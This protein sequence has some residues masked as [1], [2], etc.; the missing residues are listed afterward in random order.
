MEKI[1]CY[2]MYTTVAFGFSS[3]GR[4]PKKY[5]SFLK[6]YFNLRFFFKFHR[7]RHHFRYFLNLILDYLKV[8]FGTL[9]PNRY[10]FV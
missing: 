1:V 3:K 5:P 9:A 7:I 2:N 6:F 8:H 10:C 4:C